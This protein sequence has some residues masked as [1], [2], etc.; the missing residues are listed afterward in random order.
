MKTKVLVFFL[1]RFIITNQ[2][3]LPIYINYIKVIYYDICQVE[4]YYNYPVFKPLLY[5]TYIYTFS[6]LKKLFFI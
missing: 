3:N 2:F 4:Y 5:K 6:T 1:L